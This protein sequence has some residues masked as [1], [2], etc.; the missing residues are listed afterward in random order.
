MTESTDGGSLARFCRSCGAEFATD[1]QFC[2]QCG[3]RREVDQASP[4]ASGNPFIEA[5]NKRPGLSRR[6][7]A[8]AT[9]VVAT[10]VLALGGYGAYWSIA[11]RYDVEATTVSGLVLGHDWR[12]DR[13]VSTSCP[14][15]ED[16][17]AEIDDVVSTM[18]T[19]LQL[20]YTEGLGQ[21]SNLVASA[22]TR[23]MEWATNNLELQLGET[24]SELTSA[25]DIARNLVDVAA[26]RC[27]GDVTPVSLYA[28]AGEVDDT[29]RAINNPPMNWEGS[30]YNQSSEDPNIA[31]RWAPS[32]TYSCG[33]GDGCWKI[34]IKVHRSCPNA[35]NLEFDMMAYQN[36]T[37]WDT[38]YESLYDVRKGRTYS[39]MIYNDSW[40]IDWGRISSLTCG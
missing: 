7:K 8:I 14:T 1:V 34:Y 5:Q 33:Y 20:D 26:E 17:L 13:L 15:F 9:A 36:G 21:P 37:V 24:F 18:E 3:T 39:V 35:V 38:E 10:V 28:A 11:L 25:D 16:N 27:G 12:V 23:M 40:L 29:I 31:W 30:N 19:V 32:G 4:D 22:R 2:T 6:T